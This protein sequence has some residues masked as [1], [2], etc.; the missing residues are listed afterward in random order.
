M[1]YAGAVDEVI[2]KIM[3]IKEYYDIIKEKGG[4]N[5]DESI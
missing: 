3:Q 1:L 5:H 4:E 2:E